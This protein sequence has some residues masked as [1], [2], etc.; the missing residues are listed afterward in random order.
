MTMLFEEGHNTFQTG[1]FD[2]Y[3]ISWLYNTTVF[4][5]QVEFTNNSQECVKNQLVSSS[6]KMQSIKSSN[7]K[8][9]FER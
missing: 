8:I 2:F 9:Q 6:K 4:P 5:K 3:I 7:V 1:I